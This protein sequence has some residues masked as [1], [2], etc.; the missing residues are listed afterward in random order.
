[1]LKTVVLLNISW[2]FLKI[3]WLIKSKLIHNMSQKYLLVDKA[4]VRMIFLP[5]RPTV[6]KCF[7]KKLY[8]IQI[9]INLKIN[10]A[11]KLSTKDHLKPL[12]C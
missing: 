4:L 3:L 2:W 8:K 5:L 7:W 11:V 12:L 10:L 1:M 6:Q 9:E